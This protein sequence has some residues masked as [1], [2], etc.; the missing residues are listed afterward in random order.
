MDLSV[1]VALVVGLALVVWFLFFRGVSDTHSSLSP[2]PGS[3]T[4]F[5]SI[6]VPSGAAKKAAAPKVSKAQRAKDEGRPYVLVL[7]GSQTGTAEDFGEQLA[8]EMES[9]GIIGDLK[10]MEDVEGEAL[11]QLKHVLFVVATY[12][13]GEPTDNAKPM[14]E[15]LGKE[16][17]PE[18]APL[19][20]LQFGVFG[21]GNKT[22]EH[23]NWM[24]RELQKRLLELGASA[25]L[26]YGEG[27]DDSSLEDDFGEWKKQIWAPLCEALGVKQEVGAFD[28]GSLARAWKWQVEFDVAA[29]GVGEAVRER[30]AGKVD[31]KKRVYDK[32]HPFYTT[33]GGFRELAAP[34]CDRGCLHAEVALPKGVRYEEGDHLG[35]YPL[36]ASD[37][38]DRY[39]AYFGFDGSRICSIRGNT[40]KDRDQVLFGPAPLSRVFAAMV[41]LQDVPRKSVLEKLLQYAT[42]PSQES[43]LR[44]FLDK[45]T[46]LEHVE[47]RFMTVLEILESLPQRLVVPCHELL[48]ILPPL[49]PRYYSISSSLRYMQQLQKDKAA[50]GGSTAAGVAASAAPLSAIITCARVDYVSPT[51]RSH[52]GVTSH[53]LY[54][55][56]RAGSS[57]PVAAFVRSSTFRMPPSGRA[58]VMIGPGTGLA[59]FMGFLQR[60]SLDSGGNR[61]GD[62]L[63]TGFRSHA[64]F[65]YREELEKWAKE[66]VMELHVAFS[67]EQTEKHYVQHDLEK[68]QDS[69]WELMDQRKA[70]VYICGDANRMEKDVMATLLRIVK[71][72]KGGDEKAAQ[73]Y[74]D[75]ML[76]S[77]Q[78]QKDTW[79]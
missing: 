61:P 57:A 56:Q 43:A 50:A 21:L 1:I 31:P 45:T 42:E 75:K 55:L 15:Y 23:Y 59:P 58:A 12:G 52:P 69:V 32:D 13:E 68:N 44:A 4:A 71:G 79:F 37:L 41:D 62:I 11:S 39:L 66:G 2:T 25:V 47:K 36:N 38:V 27:D 16:L 7:F 3:T 72:K 34:G 19:K 46:Y 9:Y 67:R 60:R 65:L 63:F 77:K 73:A 28:G 10:D 14:W 30:F 26:H 22:Y 35:I 54:A 20:G 64:E 8:T 6:S 70:N 78:I 51:G 17:S 5:K 49:L 53:W 29:P 18:S 76:S 40:D 24:G 48:Q 74:I 33:I